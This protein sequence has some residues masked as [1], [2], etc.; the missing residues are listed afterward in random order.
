VKNRLLRKGFLVMNRLLMVPAFR[1][2]L[3]PIL[4]SPLGGYMMVIKTRGHLSGKTRYTPVNY[5]IS[6]GAI[7]CVAGFG[8]VSHWV[9]NMAAYPHVELLLPAGAVA[10][11]V[12]EMDEPGEKMR[13]LRQVLINSGFAAFV[14]GGINPFRMTDEQLR[15][16]TGD[17][18][19][20]RFRPT[21]IGSGAA[22][23]G[24]WLWIWPTLAILTLLWLWLR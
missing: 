18:L 12:K 8:A 13:M 9:R 15:E 19:V 20:F 1:F 17:Y 22:D 14:F 2:G 16:L 23:A 3:G 11:E 7:Y 5:A 10:C 4:G 21:G 6:D 24:G